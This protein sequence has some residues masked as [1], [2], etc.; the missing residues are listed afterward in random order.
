MGKTR[1]WKVSEK[2]PPVYFRVHAFS[3]QRTRLSRSLEQATNLD[4]ATAIATICTE[5][6]KNDDDDDDDH[7]GNTT[8]W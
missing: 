6:A 8:L 1:K 7:D 3:I 4:T 2:F 5:D